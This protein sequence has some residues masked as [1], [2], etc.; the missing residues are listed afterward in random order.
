[1][2]S[3]VAF[4]ELKTLDDDEL[5]EIK[6]KAGAVNGL[7]MVDAE[8]DR[9]FFEEEDQSELS[10]FYQNNRKNDLFEPIDDDINY[11]PFTSY[12]NLYRFPSCR[13]GG[14]GQ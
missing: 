1:M 5:S 7:M 3:G 12:E 14:C 8:Q 10:K 6:A 2:F 9:S 11:A 13:S 4:C